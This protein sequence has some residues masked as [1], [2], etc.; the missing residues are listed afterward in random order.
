MQRFALISVY[1]KEGIE[2]LASAFQDAGYQILSTGGTLEYLRGRGFNV[3]SVEELTGF[4]E[5]P[6]GRVK[7]LHPVIFAGILARRNKEEDMHFLES[8]NIP[9]IDFVVV[10]LYPFREKLDLELESLLEFIDIGGISLI[11]AAAKNYFW[12]TLVCEPG[13]YKWVAEKVKDGTLNI[14]D[15]KLLALRGFRKAIEYDSAIYFELSRR[16]EAD[17]NF[18]VGSFKKAFDLRYGENPHQKA[19]V[20]FNTLFEDTF[21][22]RAEL[23]WGTELSYNNILDF[24]SA[25]QVVNE[26]KEPACAIIKHNVPCG[27]GIGNN[28]E[29]A[30]WKALKSDE[31]SAYG[32][33]VALN[34]VV[35]EKLAQTVND[36][37]FEVLVARDY[38]EK[39]LELLKK[40]KKRRVIK[41]KEGD[42]YSLEYRFIDRDLLVQERDTRELKRE[43]LRV[44]AGEFDENWFKDVYFGDK[45][46]KYVKSNA[47]I[48]VKEGM[49]VGIGGGQTSR[50]EA[51]RIALSRAGE[52][53]RGS[54]LVSDGFFPFTDS[55]ELAYSHGIK[56]IVEPGGSVRDDEV[57]RRARELGL[58]LVFTGI[59]R[60][61]H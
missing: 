17:E 26:F 51:L 42:F 27:V 44:V 30:F 52:R 45:V 25:W 19:S 11:R 7:T 1:Y 3:V 20:Y 18:L 59:R 48:L 35:D 60:F 2:E 15:R 8:H 28:L 50:V 53:A 49:T 6:G 34:G 39:A 4:P 29:D 31:E 38:E 46:I 16:F 54:I 14:E 10:N 57:I 12:V 5:S 55:I 36:F 58:N 24:Y 41:V 33:I 32:G 9:L 13:D 22:K 23:L 37:F 40:K 47:I 21:L 56:L 61:R 43:D